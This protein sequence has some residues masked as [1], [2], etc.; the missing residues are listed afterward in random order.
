MSSA[1]SSTGKG[2]V[3]L[4]IG[5]RGSPL[6][7]WQANHIA[8]LLRP[9]LAP[10][11][12]ELVEVAT[13]GDRIRDRALSQLGGFG[14]FT[15][16]IQIALLEGHIDVAVHSL[17]DLPTIC[18]PG[19]CVQAVP[20]RGAA[21]DVLVSR[22]HDSIAALPQGATMGTSSLRRRAQLLARRPDLRL[23][24][25][26]G[27]V[28]TRLR[29]QGLDAIVLAQAGLERLGLAHVIRETL[30]WILPAIGQGAI[31]AE[32]RSADEETRQ[33]L[34]RIDDP[35]TH[36]SVTAE[37]AFLSALGGGC[38]VP[39]GASTSNSAG[40]LTLR[41]GVFSADGSKNVTG[42][43]SGPAIDPESLGKNLAQNLRRRGADDILGS[44]PVR[45]A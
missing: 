33:V 34:A 23:H 40:I 30:D 16:E 43:V 38:L 25:L 26:R 19:L 6:A 9:L 31:A 17:K 27:N 7:R 14:A 2:A 11:S 5:T 32:C 45:T 35:L 37:R 20:R 18:V 3:P 15:K 4:R 41:G 12:I 13:T 36:Q 22:D 42:T 10:R 39:I 29:L 28:E 44:P 21:R 8:E 24:D 1:G